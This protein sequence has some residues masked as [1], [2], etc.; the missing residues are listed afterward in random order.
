MRN[1]VRVVVTPKNVFR[2]II[3]TYALLLSL[4]ILEKRY[5]IGVIDQAYRANSAAEVIM[6]YKNNDVIDNL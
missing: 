4:K 1:V 5:I 6:S 2:H 3:I